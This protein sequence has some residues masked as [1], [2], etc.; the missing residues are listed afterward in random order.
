MR[1]TIQNSLYEVN[2]VTGFESI[3]PRIL[4]VANTEAKLQHTSLK[5]HTNITF[6]VL[7]QNVFMWQK[8]LYMSGTHQ[9]YEIPKKKAASAC[10][11]IL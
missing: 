9:I 3:Y 2:S 11:R 4:T 8:S 10:K 1:A 6:S 5:H 7:Q